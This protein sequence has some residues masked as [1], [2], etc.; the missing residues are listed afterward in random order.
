[1]KRT[2]IWTTLTLGVALTLTACSAPL[3]KA[4]TPAPAAATQDEATEAAAPPPAE[5][6]KPAAEAGTHANP[7]PKGTPV[8]T[9]KMTVALGEVTWNANDIVAA[10]NQFNTAA[11]AGSTYAIVPVTL[12]NVSDPEAINAMFAVTIKFVADDG[13]SFDQAFE[14]IPSQLSDVGDLYTGGVGTGNIAFL[15]PNEVS[16]GGQWAVSETFGDEVFIAAH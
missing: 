4:D 2:T 6:E 9:D 14:V 8:G 5:P 7:F 13:R 10:E 1:M 12:T 16:A 11:P 3:E 15:L